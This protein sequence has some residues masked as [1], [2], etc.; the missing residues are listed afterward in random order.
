MAQ[1]RKV[2]EARRVEEAQRVE[3]ECQAEMARQAEAARR[4][5]EVERQKAID[6]ARVRMEREQQ[7]E[8]QVQARAIMVMQGSRMPGPSTAVVGLTLTAC[9]R[10]TIHLQEP[11]GCVVSERGKVRVCL[12][13]QKACKACVWP[14]GAGGVGA[15]TGSGTEASGEPA[16]RRVRKRAERTVMN[17][18]PRGGEKG[19]KVCTTT[20]EG[21]DDD[22]TEEVFRVPRV[23][24]E[25]QHDGLGMLTQALVQ[26]AE[27][28]A[29]MEA[30]DEESLALEREMVE[31]QRAHL[32]MA[33]RAV[34]RKEERLEMDWVQL[35]IAQQWTEDL[36]KMGTLMQSPFVYLSK[37]KKRVVETEAEERGEEADDEDEDVQGEE[38]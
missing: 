30:H 37:G 10:C 1:A 20:E 6:E 21:E 36:W 22:N 33:R 34:D 19:K 16:L 17:M 5:E 9:E 28:M 7:E 29:A 32:A 4:Q 38:E 12:P 14:L 25:E 23:M 11:E 13:C 26:V 18:S 8:M 3:E 35:S 24:A 27:R 31:I 15:A 2:E